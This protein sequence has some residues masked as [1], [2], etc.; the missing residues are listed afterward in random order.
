MQIDV[1]HA[2]AGLQ[3]CIYRN[4]LLTFKGILSPFYEISCMIK[5][6]TCEMVFFLNCPQLHMIIIRPSSH[7]W[8]MFG[9]ST[10]TFLLRIRKRPHIKNRRCFLKTVKFEFLMIAGN[11]LKRA[12]TVRMLSSK[13]ITSNLMKNW[14]YTVNTADHNQYFNLSTAE[15]ECNLSPFG[16][17]PSYLMYTCNLKCGW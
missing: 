9:K 6:V 11:V 12:W 14:E 8:C 17:L 2:Q 4:W 16:V 13:S 3:T 1:P 7:F 15:A 10:D 5:P